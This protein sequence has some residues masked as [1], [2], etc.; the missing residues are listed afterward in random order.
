MAT[1]RLEIVTAERIVYSDDV[2]MVIAPGIEGQLGILPRHA[3]LLTTLQPGEL[4]IK[5]EGDE[6]SMA[7][8]GGF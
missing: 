6:I 5:K 1:L 7:V 2:N 4:R 8:T 3:P